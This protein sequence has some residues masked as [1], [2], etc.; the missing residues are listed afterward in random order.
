M[1]HIQYTIVRSGRFYY[2]RRVPKHAVSTWGQF[3]RVGLTECPSDAAVFAERLTAALDAAWKNPVP[4]QRFDLDELIAICRPRSLML[5][6]F[7]HEYLQLRDMRSQPTL[8]AVEGFI[9]V[10]GHRSVG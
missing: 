6:D 2:N 1:S 9:A 7:C 3:I 10:V 4:G 5:R 8:L